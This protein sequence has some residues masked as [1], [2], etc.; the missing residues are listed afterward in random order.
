MRISAKLVLLWLTLSLPAA[1]QSPA[2]MPENSWLAVPNSKLE[3]VASPLSSSSEL[4]GNGFYTIV[5]AWNGAVLDDKRMRL[6]IWGGGHNDYYGNEMYAF[7]IATSKW[8]QLTEP[9]LDW[10]NCDDPNADGTA[11]SRHTYNGM[12]YLSHADRFFV[13]GG[14]LNCTSGSCGA[15][16]TWT[17]DFDNTSWQNMQPSG[18]HATGCENNSSYDPGTKN[19]YFGDASGLYGYSYDS[20]AWSQLNDDYIYAMTSTVDTKRGLLVMVGGGEVW[21]YDAKNGDFTREDWATTGGD[22][23]IQHSSPGLAYDPTTD[24]IVGWAGGA[25][26]V[27]DIDAKVWT[28]YDPPGA[29]E[30]TEQGIFG[31]FRYVPTVNAFILVTATDV[32][33]HWFKLSSGGSLPPPN[34]GGSGGAGAGSGQG[35]T[36]N[37]GGGNAGVSSGGQPGSGGSSAT[38][39]DASDDGGCGCRATR[40]PASAWLSL[41]LAAL[42][43]LARRR[44]SH[45]R[46]RPSC[47]VDATSVPSSRKN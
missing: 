37:P 8:L 46:I 43:A 19:V 45:L 13:S 6:V 5:A 15:S 36:G 33:V 32:D 39:A 7:D 34:T 23:F 29:P 41:A 42:C 1:A 9:T 47:M 16:L 44:Q 10:A 22:E 40:A 28:T 4:Q 31:R 26:Y 38:P 3:A 20:N 35:G 30:P 17:F 27:L 24:R 12:S 11:N 25:V 18:E 2:D 14:A 21:A